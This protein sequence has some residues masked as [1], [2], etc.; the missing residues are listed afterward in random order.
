MPR[1]LILK[2]SNFLVQKAIVTLPTEVNKFCWESRR[3]YPTV[4][5]YCHNYAA[6]QYGDKV[7]SYDT[8]SL[9][10]TLAL[11]CFPSIAFKRF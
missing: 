8:A 2:E 1:T 5:P 7:D 11:I 9:K 4:T 6:S 10:S 3:K